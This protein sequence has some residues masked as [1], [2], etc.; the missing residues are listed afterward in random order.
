MSFEDDWDPFGDNDKFDSMFD[1]DDDWDPFGAKK[2]KPSELPFDVA[3][4]QE[5]G[6]SLEDF[7]NVMTTQDSLFHA[8]H[9]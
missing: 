1:N 5:A 2:K 7:R 6:I 4:E 9:V 8:Y 3:F